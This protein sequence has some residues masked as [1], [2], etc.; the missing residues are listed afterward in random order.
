MKLAPTRR[1]ARRTIA[2]VVL[3]LVAGL[4]TLTSCASSPS[5]LSTGWRIVLSPLDSAFDAAL[6]SVATVSSTNA[7][8]VGHSGFQPLVEHWNGTQWRVVTGPFIEAEYAE[9]GGVAAISAN[10]VWAVGVASATGLIDLVG[11]GEISRTL[12][13]H[14]GG[15]H[16][17]IVPSPNPV[18]GVNILSGVT[19]VSASDVWAVGSS[20]V[21]GSAAETLIEHWNGSRWTVIPSP[22]QTKVFSVLNAVTAVSAN[23]IWAVGSA[24]AALPGTPGTLEPWGSTM[25]LVEHWNGAQWSIVPSTN[26]VLT[27]PG[28]IVVNSLY[29]V[30]AIS[31]DDVW[32]VGNASSTFPS[33]GKNSMETLIEHWNGTGWAVVPGPSIPSIRADVDPVP[34]LYGVL[35]ISTDDIWAVGAMSTANFT[36]RNLVAHWNGASWRNVPSPNGYYGQNSLSAVAAT[37]AVDVWAVGSDEPLNA[38]NRPNQGLVIHGP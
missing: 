10:D 16:W 23:D 34:G 7:W 24:T 32:A 33:T 27:S 6:S 8:A 11:D 20:R 29:G 22:N 15:S 2:L 38:A 14:W 37:S 9:L 25:T 21:D 4:L 1:D 5:S 3:L 26:K 31:P 17:S 12:I 28:Y 35:A 30:S 13:E 18:N 19:A 36:N